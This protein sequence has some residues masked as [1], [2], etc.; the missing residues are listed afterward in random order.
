[1][2]SGRADLDCICARV[3]VRALRSRDARQAAPALTAIT[4]SYHED[5][6]NP[7]DLEERFC[8]KA[9]RVLR[10][11]SCLREERGCGHL[12]AHVREGC[13]RERRPATATVGGHDRARNHGLGDVCE[14]H[15]GGLP[16]HWLRRAREAASGS[17]PGRR[18]G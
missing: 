7:E 5:T 13:R 18:D 6:K 17:S 8:T 15:A 14:P 4:T 12:R 9:F 1:G 2:H 3:A 10:G 11:A 16:G